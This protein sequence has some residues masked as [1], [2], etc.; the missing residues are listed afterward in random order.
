MTQLD[1]FLARAESLLARL[2]TILPPAAQSIDWEAGSAYRWRKSAG[3]ARGYLQ[4]VRHA[5]S[6]GLSDLHYIEMKKQ[7][8]EHNTRQFDDGMSAI[9]VLLIVGRGSGNCWLIM[10][11]L[12]HYAGHGLRLI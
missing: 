1:Q 6:I 10:A 7:Q 4:P 12:I 11:C 5:S 3:N 9:I 8:I 2:E